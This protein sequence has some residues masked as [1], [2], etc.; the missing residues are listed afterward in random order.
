MKRLIQILFLLIVLG[1]ITGYVFKWKNDDETGDIFI[2]I[3]ILVTSFILM[4]LFIFHRGK[5]KKIQDY[6]LTKE[7]LDKMQEEKDKSPE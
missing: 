1:I 2:G 5:G 4:P 7:N 3:S 6:M